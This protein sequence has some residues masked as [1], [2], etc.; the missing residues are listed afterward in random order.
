M[1]A[2]AEEVGVRMSTPVVVES[3]SLLPPAA[4]MG[5]RRSSSS[6][7]L[8]ASSASPSSSAPPSASPSPPRS[9]AASRRSSLL[10]SP[11]L[12]PSQPSPLRPTPTSL[13]QP[14]GKAP[15]TPSYVSSLHAFT[16]SLAQPTARYIS[17]LSSST[18]YSL[19]PHEQAL[20]FAHYH[21]SGADS[22]GLPLPAFLCLV[23]DVLQSMQAG[24]V[25][26]GLRELS[27]R[28][29]DWLAEGGGV[30]ALGGRLFAELDRQSKGR[31]EV[32]DFS[33]FLV[34][35]DVRLGERLRREWKRRVVLQQLWDIARL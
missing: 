32:D 30:E 35:L 12:H 22:T 34:A 31:L 13:Q 21:S 3:V 24:L 16:A 10:A 2:V 15:P 27:E 17:P 20:L 14:H 33:N 28:V 7:L 5:S 11:S 25:A 1:A 26:R 18:L 4:S 9:V 19:T 23:R 29:Q 8:S 6:V